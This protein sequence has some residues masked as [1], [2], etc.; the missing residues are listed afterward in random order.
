MPLNTVAAMTDKTAQQRCHFPW[1][2]LSFQELLLYT[3]R[4]VMEHA[5]QMNLVLGRKAGLASDWI[6]QVVT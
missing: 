1:M 4:H 3:M 2:E 5:A 6:P